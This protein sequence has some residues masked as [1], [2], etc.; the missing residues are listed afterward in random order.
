MTTHQKA[1]FV[2]ALEKFTKAATEFS[3]QWSCVD[4]TDDEIDIT[5]GIPV[6]MSFD[7]FALQ[8]DSYTEEVVKQLNSIKEPKNFK[9]RVILTYKEFD[10]KGLGEIEPE[11]VEEVY[12]YD[13]TYWIVKRHT[14]PRQDNKTYWTE[15]C[16]IDF[17][18]NNLTELEELLYNEIQ[19]L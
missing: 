1:K 9:S 12:V 19:S 10:K 17:K 18:S 15:V 7:E 14:P 2:D 16:G 3:Y 6:G 4:M 8:L 13:N 11:F 5:A